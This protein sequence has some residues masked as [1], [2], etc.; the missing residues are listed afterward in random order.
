[1][2][3]FE[4]LYL[5]EGLS[6][7]TNGSCDLRLNVY[8]QA[9]FRNGEIK[10]IDFCGWRPASFNDRGCGNI[11]KYVVIGIRG[12]TPTLHWKSGTPKTLRID[13]YKKTL[14]LECFTLSNLTKRRCAVV[15]PRHYKEL[16]VRAYCLDR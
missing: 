13:S 6:P 5:Q 11:V 12:S 15:V 3:L 8:N 16:S 14:T 1:M 4:D 7:L 10:A 9:R 2:K